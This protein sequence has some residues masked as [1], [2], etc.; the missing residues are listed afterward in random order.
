M[1]HGLYVISTIWH[2]YRS[3]G[4]IPYTYGVQIS[5]DLCLTKSLINHSKW[6]WGDLSLEQTQLPRN[7]DSIPHIFCGI[8]SWDTVNQ[9]TC[10][11]ECD[12]E[13]GVQWTCEFTDYIWVYLNGHDD[14]HRDATPVARWV[15][16]TG[17]VNSHGRCVYNGVTVVCPV[18]AS[19]GPITGVLLIY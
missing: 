9:W 11:S 19:W 13:Y 6:H 12:S 3:Y 16:C 1:V 2:V 5:T 18:W 8:P 14:H 7:G 4:I 17:T 10:D 15:V